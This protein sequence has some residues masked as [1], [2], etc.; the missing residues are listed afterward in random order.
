MTNYDGLKF[1]QSVDDL[2]IEYCVEPGIDYRDFTEEKRMEIAKSDAQLDLLLQENM[3]KI[4]ALNK[5]I[6]SVTVKAEAEDY[7]V[8]AC[9]GVFAGLLDVFMVGE[10]ANSAMDVADPTEWAK[11]RQRIQLSRWPSF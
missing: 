10:V 9:C 4:N 1:K 8:A 7:V 6:E 11:N 2:E 3:D 5:Q